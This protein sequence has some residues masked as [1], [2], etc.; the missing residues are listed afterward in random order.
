VIWVKKIRIILKIGLDHNM[1]KKF[2]SIILVFC[3]VSFST[4]VQAQNSESDRIRA[5]A[6]ASGSYHATA[7]SMV[8]WGLLLVTGIAIAAVLI[9]S[10]SSSTAHSE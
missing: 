5:D 7:I 8:F 6:A 3:F 4:N 2:I 10:A 1:K 9:D